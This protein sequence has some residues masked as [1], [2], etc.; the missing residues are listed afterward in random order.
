MCRDA[1]L[2]A[3]R[4]FLEDVIKRGF[5][6]PHGFTRELFLNVM[7]TE[8]VMYL[9]GDSMETRNDMAHLFSHALVNSNWLRRCCKHQCCGAHTKVRT[10]SDVVEHDF[11]EQKIPI[12]LDILFAFTTSGILTELEEFKNMFSLQVCIL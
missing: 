10:L 7:R 9:R 11:P 12:L 3:E 8:S 5:H 2:F 4:K 6:L 1:M